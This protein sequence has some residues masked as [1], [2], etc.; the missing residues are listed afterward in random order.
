MHKGKLIRC[1]TP[2]AMKR[3]T[4]TASLE[5]AFIKSIHE[6]EALA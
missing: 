3:E 4:A 1:A 5:G 6:V 2:D